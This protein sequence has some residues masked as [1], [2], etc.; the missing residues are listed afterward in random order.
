MKHPDHDKRRRSCLDGERKAALSKLGKSIRRLGR[1]TCELRLAE[2]LALIEAVGGLGKASVQLSFNSFR[3]LAIRMGRIEQPN[4]E[5][6]VILNTNNHPD[7]ALVGWSVRTAARYV[8]WPTLCLCQ[9]LAGASMLKRRRISYRLILG[10]RRQSGGDIAHAWLLADGVLTG[11][12]EDP[13]DY[14]LIAAF[15]G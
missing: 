6:F 11:D 3:H 7:A 10:T 13:E 8:P 5:D 14:H 1:R 2:W 12:H 9:A 4:R 15:L